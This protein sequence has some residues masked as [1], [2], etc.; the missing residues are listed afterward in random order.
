MLPLEMADV[1]IIT[2]TP[3]EYQ[4]VAEAFEAV[5]GHTA[6]PKSIGDRVYHD[7][8]LVNHARVF[9]ALSEMGSQGSGSA[10][11]AVQKG[12][13]A[14]RPHA[15][16]MIGIAFG[17]DD[18]KQKIGEILVSKQLMLYDLQRVGK[19]DEIVLRGD[20]TS[21]TPRLLDYLRNA[22][23]KWQN[24]KVH[25]GLV[26]TGEKL[27]DDLDYR[28]S[29]QKLAP[30]A[31]GGE[32]EGAGLYV[33]CQDAKVDWIVVKAICDWADGN[34]AQDKTQRQQ[35]AAKNAAD[36]VVHALQYASLPR[37]STAHIN[38]PA[39]AHNE[40]TL[41]FPPVLPPDYF[42]G[43]EALLAEIHQRLQ[44]NAVVLLVNGLG[45]IGKTVSAQVY[46]HRYRADYQ[47]VAWVLVQ[48]NLAQDLVRVMQLALRLEFA[49]EMPLDQQFEQVI[50]ELQ[51][52]S[53]RNL[54]IVD[55][56]NNS[57]ELL[58][59][60]RQLKTTGWRVLI[61]SRC[62]PDDYDMVAVD[63]LPEAEAID[64]FKH[65]YG[66]P[67]EPA[68]LSKLLHKI[69]YH[70]LLIELVAK[71]GKK[72]GFSVTQLLDRLAQGFNHN[73]LQRVITVGEHADSHQVSK[74]TTLYGYILTLFEP[75]KLSTEEQ[76]ILRYFS[77]FPAGDIAL[78]HLKTL[79]QVSE[80]QQNHFEDQLDQ[81]YQAG[82]LIQKIEPQGYFY[83]M[84]A[85]VQDVVWVKLQTT[86]EN[87]VD[88]IDILSELLQAHLNVAMAFQNIA[89]TVSQKFK[90]ASATDSSLGLFNLYLSDFYGNMGQLE[91]AL[92]SI[93]LARQQFEHC[94]DRANLAVAYSR[95]GAIHQALGHTD[96][97]LEF[98]ELCC[99]LGKELYEIRKVRD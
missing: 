47:H 36:F 61:T 80:D 34:K 16:I 94:E 9:M 43:R 57:Q 66:L 22:S 12:I 24:T 11:Q 53:G 23:F 67:V 19:Q 91:P 17:I 72:K 25:F 35:Q 76:R 37:L 92:V 73:D 15:V 81:L 55:N 6:F 64:L 63:E 32:M 4:A 33:S 29:L 1:L 79:F 65:Y 45:G 28:N 74:Q 54:L 42:I 3:M 98:F 40:K 99:Q 18:E 59:L 51:Q 27:V 48:T 8:G 90:Q 71:V 75:D 52:V 62:A 20:R 68:E 7:L 21:S 14:L 5:T 41:H 13:A 82:W 85:L 69:S 86:P 58:D 56:A 77:A 96:T 83:K 84:H 78:S 49:A 38:P 50:R 2:V 93:E 60:R 39:V 30:D 46:G 89:Q 95:I 10:Q 70:T 26:L 31:I 88:L 97:A 87:C 44:Q